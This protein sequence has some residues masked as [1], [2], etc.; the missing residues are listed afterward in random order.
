[1]KKAP[2]KAYSGSIKPQNDAKNDTVI[3]IGVEIDPTVDIRC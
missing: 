1:M 2:R 3:S